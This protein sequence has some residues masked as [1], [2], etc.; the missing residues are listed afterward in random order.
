MVQRCM[1][2]QEFAQVLMKEFE[3]L[4]QY[5]ISSRALQNSYSNSENVAL[6]TSSSEQDFNLLVNNSLIKHSVYITIFSFTEYALKRLAEV[7]AIHHQQH[8]RRVLNFEKMHQYYDFICNEIGL[9]KELSKELW[10]QIN[11]YRDIRNSIIHHN[12]AIGRNI[13]TKTYQFLTT[14]PRIDFNDGT[15]TINDDNLT[16]ELVNISK[17]FFIDILEVYKRNFEC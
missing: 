12:S 4:N 9:G 14:D 13:S 17:D 5:I 10:Q 8:K 2:Y 6:T 1:P 3:K 11:V 15:F 7:L 16:E